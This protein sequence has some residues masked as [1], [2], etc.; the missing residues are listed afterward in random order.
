[1][2]F[3]E[4]KGQISYGFLSVT[5]FFY[6]TLGFMSTLKSSKVSGERGCVVQMLEAANTGKVFCLAEGD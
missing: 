4:A 1:M 2:F 5:G 3:S 6:D